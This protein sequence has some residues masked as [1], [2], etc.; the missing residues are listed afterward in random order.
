MVPQRVGRVAAFALA[1]IVLPAA[2]A[3]DAASPESTTLG[4]RAG[5]GLFDGARFESAEEWLGT[6]IY[7]TAQFAGKQTPRDMNGSVFGLLASDEATLP[8]FADR[9]DLSLTVPLAFG[10]ANAQTREGR[11]QIAANLDA[12]TR[13]DHDDAYRRVARRLVEAGYEDAIVRLGHEFNGAWAPWSSRTNED[14]FIAA[15]RHVHDVLSEEAPGLRFEWTALR[16]AWFEWGEAAYPGDDYVDIV[17]LDLYWRIQPRDELWDP[18][19]WERQFLKVMRDHHSFAVLHDKPVAYPEWGLQGGDAPQFIEAMHE[20]LGNL[21][22]AG[23]G[24]L[25]YHS[26]FDS[27]NAYALDQYPRSAATYQDLFGDP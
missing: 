7:F 5:G 26:Y 14:H 23:P 16:P 27:G 6:S 19:E 22:E 25:L 20:W 24:R 3:P 15:W 9:L 17:G 21:P 12:V 10:D 8:D 13:G 1:S 4:Y 2:C 11:D 18:V